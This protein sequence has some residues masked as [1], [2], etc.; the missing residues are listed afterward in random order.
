MS[1]GE[2]LN[3]LIAQVGLVGVGGVV[4][5]GV[6]FSPAFYFLGWSWKSTRTGTLQC[7]TK[8]TLKKQTKQAKK[9]NRQCFSFLIWHNPSR[10]RFIS[11]HSFTAQY[12]Q[13][14]QFHLSPFH[15]THTITQIQFS[16][17]SVQC[18]HWTLFT[19]KWIICNGHFSFSSYS[20]SQQHMTLLM[21]SFVTKTPSPS[22][23]APVFRFSTCIPIP[24]CKFWA[25]FAGSYSSSR[26][27]NTGV[28]QG[29]NEG[30]IWF[31]FI[32]SYGFNCFPYTKDFQFIY[33][34]RSSI[35]NSHSFFSTFIDVK[36]TNLWNI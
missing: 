7:L 6:M 2:A 21:T 18:L 28:P 35:N 27:L 12:L 8:S 13:S 26:A 11:F 33:P 23:M 29:W 4:R 9:Q 10:H 20:I 17:L 31:S 34:T 25:P 16:L 36:L 14:W 1:S 15:V 30:F 5:V 24:S 22:F 19:I 3:P 32:C